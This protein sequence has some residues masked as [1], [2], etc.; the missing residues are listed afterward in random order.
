MVESKIRDINNE[1]QQ[2]GYFK[3]QA[4]K[5]QIKSQALEAS[6]SK[7]SE[8]LRQTTRENRVVRERTKIQHEQHKEEVIVLTF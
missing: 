8:K 7:V 3:K 2:V 4:A 1:N 6:L 5:E